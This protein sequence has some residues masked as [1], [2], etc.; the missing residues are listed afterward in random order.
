MRL[1]LAVHLAKSNISIAKLQLGLDGRAEKSCWGDYRVLVF[2]PWTQC[3]FLCPSGFRREVSVGG[4]GVC[5]HIASL[6][7]AK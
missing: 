4:N 3:A 1:D 5:I 2:T 6:A 7:C